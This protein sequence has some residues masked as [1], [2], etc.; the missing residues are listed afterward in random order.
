MQLIS[1]LCD[2]QFQS[3]N[4]S[5]PTFHVLVIPASDLL[6]G[7]RRIFQR[8]IVR[9]LLFQLSLKPHC[10]V[11]RRQKLFLQFI[12]QL[13]RLLTVRKGFHLQQLQLLVEGSQLDTFIL[14]QSYLCLLLHYL[15]IALLQNA[16]HLL[17]HLVHRLI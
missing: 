17:C 6:L 8:Q 12:I 5:H 15:R 9:L 16:V 4:F 7:L 10:I 1:K 11:T 2:L 14:K 3:L 13:L